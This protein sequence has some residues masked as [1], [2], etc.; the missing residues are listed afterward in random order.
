M[1][2]RSHS[3]MIQKVFPAAVL[4]T[5]R[6]RFPSL[7]N[8]SLAARSSAPIS[9]QSPRWWRSRAEWMSLVGIT[10]RA[11][12]VAT[13]RPS[14]HEVVCNCMVAPN[15][16]VPALC[17]LMGLGVTFRLGLEQEVPYE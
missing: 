11:F 2:G 3:V 1:A 9:P 13:K 10:S 8:T 17:P 12:W 5:E 14:C 15:E 6:S 4:Y 16:P 7:S